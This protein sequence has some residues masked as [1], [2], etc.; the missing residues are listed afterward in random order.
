MTA[1]HEAKPS[2]AQ[3]AVH[4]REE[5]Y[6]YPSA[7]F[8]GQANASDPAI[9]ERFGEDHFPECFKE[10]ADLLDW[11]AYWHTTL[12]TSNPP[13]W[14]WF[15]GGRLNACHN[16]V[17]RHLATSPNKAALIWVP[18]PETEQSQAITYRDLHRRV[19]EFAALLR[20]FC[21]LKTGDRV[22]FHLPMVPELPVAML[23]CARLGVIHSEVFGGFSGAA[24]GDRIADSQSR[25]LVTM[26]GYYRNGELVD[27]KTRGD[28]AVATAAKLGAEVDKVLVWRRHP[29]QYASQSA[30]VDGRDFFVDEVLKDYRGRLVEPVSMPAEAP[31]FLMYTS[32]TTARPKGCQHS[33]GGYLSYV[34]GTS[35]YYQD[36]HPDDTYWCMADIGWITGH[37]YIVYGPLS[38]GTTS[39][40]YEGVPTYPDPGRPWRIAERLGVNIFHTAPTAIRM[41][42]KLGPDEPHKYGY[43][44]KHMT[45]VGEPI[46]PEVWRW[47]YD[48]VGK[49]E[50]VIVDT[51][52]Q[53]E[54]GGFLGST[55]PALQ[56]MKPGSCG[57]GVL[58]IYPVIYDEDRNVVPAGSG[59]AGNICIRNPWPGIFQTIWGQPERFVE[60]YYSKYCANPDSTDWRDWPY[61]AGDGAMLAADGYFR[62]L[63]RVDDVINVAGHRLGTKELESASITVDEVAEAAA[64]PVMDELRGRAVEIYISL[65]P[66]VT[67]GKDIEDKVVAA[68][69]TQIGKIARPKNVWIVADMPK[70]RS[71]KIMRRVIA[72]ISNFADVGDVTTLSN[73]EIVDD[74]RHRVQAEK[75]A[76]GEAPRE[77]TPQEETEIKAFGAAE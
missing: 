35:K 52:W 12:D 14:K 64:V 19:N 18:E 13:F 8:I 66:G 22:T 7:R 23:A 69:E 67:A 11:D 77:L 43:R 9:F 63:G 21:G 28:E 58:G 36:I 32:G 50:A 47:Y 57:P 2:E 59:K 46:E 16:C 39:V 37:S 48:V 44:F 61:L 54:N 4:W 76:R 42:R 62:I 75:L 55:L 24:C 26:D 73:P 71:G 38:L 70:T 45:T 72:S 27:H 1:E 34:T 31:L 15:V 3:I 60:L 17:D 65:K 10:Y 41:L 33:T 74:I 30:M 20:D 6:Y 40:I 53:T 5:G 29:G 68:I 56:P 51:W 49:G 25:V